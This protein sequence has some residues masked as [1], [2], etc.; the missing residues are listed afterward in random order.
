MKNKAD[1]QRM[2]KTEEEATHSVFNP[3]I[4]QTREEIIKI[5]KNKLRM[6]VEMGKKI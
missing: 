4:K 6:D 3:V 1:A 2:K 5:C